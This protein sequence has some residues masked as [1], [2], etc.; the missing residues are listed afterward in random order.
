M[1]STTVNGTAQA[2]PAKFSPSPTGET[3]AY[4]D[5]TRQG[6]LEVPRCLDC[7]RPFFYP[8]SS[9]PRCGSE[10][11]EQLVCTGRARLL[12]YVVSHRPAPGFEGPVVIAIV[13]LEEG[14]RMMTN[15]VGVPPDPDALPLDLPLTVLFEQRGD[16]AVPVFTPEESR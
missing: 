3:Q 16:L 12:S 7:R 11:L 6:R 4:W 14:P 15:I 5:A 2:A 8:R 10:R 13:E 1:T 9:C